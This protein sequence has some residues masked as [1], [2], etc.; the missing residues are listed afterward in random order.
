MSRF[1]LSKPINLRPS[2]TARRTQP[3]FRARPESDYGHIGHDTRLFVWERDGGRCQHCGS[4]E[5]LQFDHVIP[6]SLG[7]S[8][9]ASNVE[10]LCG[11]CNRRKAAML[12]PPPASNDGA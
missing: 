11:R 6:R 9:R 5:D 2:R 3:A 1:E 10:L 12:C 8:G 4:T 7:G